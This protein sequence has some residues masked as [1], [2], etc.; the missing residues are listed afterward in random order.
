MKAYRYLAL[1]LTGL[2]CQFPYVSQAHHS[3]VD[4]D[5]SIRDASVTGVVKEFDVRNPHT[6]IVLELSDENGTRL[7]EYEGDS[8]GNWFR[9]GWRPGLVEV[10]DTI[11]LNFAPRRDG[12]DGGFCRSFV[13]A[14]GTIIGRRQGP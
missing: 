5:F 7:A 14:D 6:R 8:R 1:A 9:A 10:G 13:T 4:F 3:G 12:T 11:T 2:W